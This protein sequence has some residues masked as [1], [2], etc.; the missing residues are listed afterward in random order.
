MREK[1]NFDGEDRECQ[2]KKALSLATPSSDLHSPQHGFD[3]TTYNPHLDGPPPKGIVIDPNGDVTM[4]VLTPMHSDDISAWRNDVADPDSTSTS[5]S[6]SNHNHVQRSWSTTSL[7]SNTSLVPTEIDIPPINW[8]NLIE[9]REELDRWGVGV[10]DFAYLN[11]NPKAK[12]VTPMPTLNFRPAPT[13][14]DPYT[15]L[16]TYEYYLSR[17]TSESVEG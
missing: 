10:R 15:S 9:A 12:Q 7:A 3:S 11:P 1:I 16:A 8:D 6:T 13:I 14:F 5:T 4:L 17:G 2:V